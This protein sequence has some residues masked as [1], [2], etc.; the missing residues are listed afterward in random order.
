MQATAEMHVIRL[1]LVGP[2]FQDV[3]VW[4]R[5]D[6]RAIRGTNGRRTRAVGRYYSIKTGESH[7]W[8]SRPELLDMYHAEVSD[9]VVSY[10]TQ[11]ETLVWRSDGQR[12]RY[13]PDRVDW[14]SDGSRCLTEVKDTYDESRDPDYSDKLKTA[15]EIYAHLGLPLVMRDRATI[16]AEPLF[17]AV[18][19]VQ[20]YR[21]AVVTTYQACSVQEI[22]ASGPTRLADLAKLLPPPHPRQSILAMAVR[23]I[24]RLDITHGL[25]DETPVL[26]LSRTQDAGLR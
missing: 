12:R 21:C 19:E 14:L 17:S 9:W 2:R 13:T 10:L 4:R 5:Q 24:L 23:R 15:T 3:E 8:E 22:L 11:P 25:S 26:R 6:G 20:A 18:E 7:W 16:T 1:P